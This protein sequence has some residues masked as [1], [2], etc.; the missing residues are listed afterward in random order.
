CTLQCVPLS[1][2]RVSVCGLF[3]VCVC[4]CVCGVCV[5]VCVSLFCLH[6]HVTILC[7]SLPAGT[8]HV[9]EYHHTLSHVLCAFAL[10]CVCVLMS[11][12]EDCGILCAH[13]P[14]A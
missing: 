14:S 13:L 9:C 11:M 8:F 2:M 6:F 5:C 1:F 4:V 7:H 3:G 12:W 10:V